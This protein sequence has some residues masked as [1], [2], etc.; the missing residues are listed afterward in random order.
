MREPTIAIVSVL[1]IAMA[2]PVAMAAGDEIQRTA[3]GVP[4]LTGVY[5]ITSI[6]PFV[7][8]KEFG[9]QLYLSKEEA[10]ALA[11]AQVERDVERSQPSDPD[12]AAPESGG[13]VGAYN[14]FWF[15]WG[16]AGFA[17]DGKYRTSV[18]TDP[19][20]GQMPELTQLG[21]DRRA[22]APRF[23]WQNKGF[24][25]WLESGDTPYDGPENMVLGVRCLYQPTATMAMRSLPYNNLKTIVQTEDHVM[26]QSEWMHWARVVRLDSEHLPQDIRSLSGD[27]IG[28]FEGDTL[29][30]ETTNFLDSPGVRGEGLKVVESFTALSEGNLSYKFTVEDPDYEAPYSGE[31][32]WP[33]TA[34]R[35]YEYACH[36]GN[37][38][39]GNMLRGARMLEEE[40]RAK[41][42]GSG[43]D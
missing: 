35:S 32:L 13:N 43:N 26:I 18:L 27:S 2:A 16:D 22:T 19:P 4:D 40:F 20:D 1:A 9:E 25:W 36:E 42:S 7:R 29:V 5:D 21:K 38:A 34:K 37:Y 12:R 23:A 33:K 39:M 41:Q 30:V 14:D 15:E 6:T 10:E 8:P 31:L 11:K 3:S 24:A 28:W 17:I